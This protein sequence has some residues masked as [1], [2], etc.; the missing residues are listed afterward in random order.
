MTGVILEQGHQEPAPSSLWSLSS[1]ARPA[2][3]HI[4]SGQWVGPVSRAKLQ[5]MHDGHVN[6]PLFTWDY[7]FLQHDL[8]YP[9]SCMFLPMPQQHH[10]HLCSLY[11]ILLRLLIYLFTFSQRLNLHSFFSTPWWQSPNSILATMCPTNSLRQLLTTWFLLESNWPRSEHVT[12][13]W[14][15]RSKGNLPENSGEMCPFW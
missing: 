9:D 6:K 3:Y 8:A 4:G 12:K 15:V 13:F 14:T 10:K 2:T 11:N 5:W 1:A 7:L